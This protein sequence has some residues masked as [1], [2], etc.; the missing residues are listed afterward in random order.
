MDRFKDHSKTNGRASGKNLLAW[1]EAVNPCTRALE[2]SSS[3]NN[4]WSCK[5]TSLQ[6]P[7]KGSSR[8]PVYHS[9]NVVLSQENDVK[10]IIGSHGV[11]EHA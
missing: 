11:A 1:L 6:Q 8:A 4:P 10:L 7:T 5:R 3:A 9:L 2:L